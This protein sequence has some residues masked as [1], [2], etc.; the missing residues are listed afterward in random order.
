MSQ[1]KSNPISLSKYQ[2]E[3]LERIVRKHTSPQ[4][5]V[6]RAKIILLADQGRG[7]RETSRSLGI[8]RDQVLRWRRR[9][10]EADCLADVSLVLAEAARS[11]A[12]A[13]YTPQIICAVVAIACER[14]EV[15][16]RPVTH[17]TQQEIADETIKRGIVGNISQRSVGRFLNEANL[18]PHRVRGWLP[19]KQEDQCDQKSDRGKRFCEQKLLPRSDICETYKQALEREKRGEKTFPLMK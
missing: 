13:T 19:P 17:W 3:D 4:I 18:Q 9:W 15:C 6:T 11:G 1:L 14:S 12:P 5:L 8:S 2:C 16:S 7:V 10:L